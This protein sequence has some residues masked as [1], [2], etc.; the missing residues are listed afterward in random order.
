MA[1]KVGFVPDGKFRRDWV[2]YCMAVA[3][4]IDLVRFGEV[5]RDKVWQLRSGLV[6]S[7][8]AWSG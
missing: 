7:G 4:R 6:W 1:V 5:G 3:E 8:L 2:R